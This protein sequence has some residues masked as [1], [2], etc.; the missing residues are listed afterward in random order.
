MEKLIAL[1]VIWGIAFAITVPLN[2]KRKK[3]G[4]KEIE[5]TYWTAAFLCGM[6]IPM[7]IV[8]GYRGYKKW[9]IPTMFS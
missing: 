3:E 6:W 8:I 2:K 7:L 1:I 9:N 4:K 5:W